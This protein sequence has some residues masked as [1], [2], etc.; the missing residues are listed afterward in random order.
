LTVEAPKT[1]TTAS[2]SSEEDA[3]VTQTPESTTVSVPPPKTPEQIEQEAKNNG[4]LTTWNEFSWWYPWYRLHIKLSV[5][6]TVD[7]GFNPILPGGEVADW[8]GLEFFGAVVGEVIEETL[9]EATTFIGTYLV[10]RTV[11]LAQPWIGG[12]MEFAKIVLQTALFLA[13]WDDALR[14]LATGLVSI[15]MSFFAIVNFYTQP[16]IFLKFVD[17]LWSICGSAK[18][19]LRWMLMTLT[20]M[21]LVGKAVS[22][23][24]IDAV[25]ATAD[26]VIGLTALLRYVN[27]TA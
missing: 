25:E 12:V 2:A 5:N 7:I 10:A 15:A 9:I 8:S 23:S 24:W 27:L 3:T 19:A 14:M 4:W 21:A 18:G 13:D 1:D 26:F 20:D 6:P 22:R 16:N 11:G 17:V